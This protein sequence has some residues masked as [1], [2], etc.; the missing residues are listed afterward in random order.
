MT[1]RIDATRLG[2]ILLIG[3]LLAGCANDDGTGP[4]SDDTRIEFA[5]TTSD[6]VDV[7][8]ILASGGAPGVAYVSLPPATIPNGIEA[9]IENS[10]TGATADVLLGAGGFDP[11]PISANADDTLRIDVRLSGGGISYARS[12]V[13]AR[14][15]PRV[16]RTTPARGRTDVAINSNIVI[17]FSEPIAPAT[18]TT[19][20]IR[21]LANGVAIPGQIHAVAG[22]DVAVEW[23]P[24]APLAADTDHELSLSEAISDRTGDPI[25]GALSITFR[26]GPAAAPMTQV[27]AYSV[28]GDIMIA[29]AD[30]SDARNLLRTGFG[31]AWSPDGTRLAFFL[32]TGGDQGL[33]VLNLARIGSEVTSEDLVRIVAPIGSDW[34]PD[35]SPDGSRIAFGS[36]GDILVVNADGTNLVRLAGPRWGA[37]YPDWSPDGTRIAYLARNATRHEFTVSVMNADGSND[38]I[39]VEGS[40]ASAPVWSHDGSRL[41]FFAGPCADWF[42][43]D[44]TGFYRYCERYAEGPF[45]MAVNPD[46]SGLTRL[47]DIP[48]LTGMEP[49]EPSPDGQ[50][51][52][53]SVS[54]CYIRYEFD[55][56]QWKLQQVRLSD[57][58]VTDLM[59]G[60]EPSWRR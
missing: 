52:I 47:A 43:W 39:L 30:G 59:A 3:F 9:V 10:R 17:V 24:A 29:N 55:T 28:Q 4:N 45:L 35:W 1:N 21:L 25:E 16:I 31:P 50:S 22:S 58:H 57:G 8:A 18:L 42:E 11:V 32:S 7:T 12:V 46:G 41:L 38:R 54:D 40:V 26:T 56:C 20:R 34:D 51:V 2:T 27:L 13:P 33:H 5:G 14:K 60:T 23:V 6:P 19:D 37:S 15:R 44:A 49:P 36:N 53:V 48:I